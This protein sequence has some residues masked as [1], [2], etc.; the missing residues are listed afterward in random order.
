MDKLNQVEEIMMDVRAFD[1]GVSPNQ[2]RY[3]FAKIQDIK[4]N[5]KAKQ[6][7]GKGSIQP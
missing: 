4:S 5:A 3:L 1:L 7:K 6:R 2:Y